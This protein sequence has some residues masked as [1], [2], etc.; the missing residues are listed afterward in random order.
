[1]LRSCESKQPQPSSTPSALKPFR[2]PRSEAP[3]HVRAAKAAILASKPSPPPRAPGTTNVRF[4][5]VYWVVDQQ[6]W[7]AKHQKPSGSKII[8]YFLD[9]EDAAEAYHEYCTISVKN[10]YR[11]RVCKS[12]EMTGFYPTILKFPKLGPDIYLTEQVSKINTQTNLHGDQKHRKGHEQEKAGRT[13]TKSEKRCCFISLLSTMV[14]LI[15]I[16]KGGASTKTICQQG[17]CGAC[18]APTRFIACTQTGILPIILSV[19][20]SQLSISVCLILQQVAYSLTTLL[21]A[22]ARKQ[23][24][25][26]NLM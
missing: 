14:C 21:K 12:I 1:M 15:A 13:S 6:R 23:G 11:D 16:V 3:A 4:Q 9:E 5:G 17:S 25:I 7:M 26:G 24:Q 18:Y 20:D 8:G 19:I 10:K 2:P 22:N